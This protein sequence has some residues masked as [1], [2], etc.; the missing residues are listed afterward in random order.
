VINDYARPSG[1]KRLLSAEEMA[2]GLRGFAD[3][4]ERIPRITSDL[5]V[6]AFTYS[7]IRGRL[8]G[9]GRDSPRT[10]RTPEAAG[11]ARELRNP[12]SLTSTPGRS[13]SAGGTINSRE[14]AG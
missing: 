11:R 12:R 9:P 10:S 2:R 3:G 5:R 4:Y 8:R 14:P 13:H 1:A 6:P 7:G